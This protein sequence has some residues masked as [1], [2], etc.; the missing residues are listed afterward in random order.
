MLLLCMCMS[1]HAVKSFDSFATCTSFYYRHALSVLNA[2]CVRD[3]E[4][5]VQCTAILEAG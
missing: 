2:G 3:D 5:R 4:R 1:N